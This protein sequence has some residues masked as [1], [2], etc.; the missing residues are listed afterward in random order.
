M[1]AYDTI[2]ALA[3]TCK[4]IA[5]EA[6]GLFC[7]RNRFNITIKPFYNA[8]DGSPMLFGTLRKSWVAEIREWVGR[9]QVQ[10]KNAI[11]EVEFALLRKPW[12]NGYHPGPADDEISSAL[13]TCIRAVR[14]EFRQDAR[15]AML[16]TVTCE[17]PLTHVRRTFHLKLP[18]GDSQAIKQI[19][20][21]C[22][23]EQMAKDE[24]LDGIEQADIDLLN[25]KHPDFVALW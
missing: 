15:L 10:G 13:S 23:S 4:G 24:A 7:G 20:Y 18:L 6:P 2:F 14:D 16:F 22:K 25:D 5:T 17:Y 9:E 8:S 3:R 19:L 21:G 1:K 11:R 12:I